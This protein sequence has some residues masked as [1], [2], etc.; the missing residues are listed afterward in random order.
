[1]GQISIHHFHGHDPTNW[2][3]EDGGYKTHIISSV[4]EWIAA[5]ALDFFILSFTQEF[6]TFTIQ[7]PRINLHTV[8]QYDILNSSQNGRNSM[9][10]SGTLVADL[11]LHSGI[12]H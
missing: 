8:E 7:T 10:Q 11:S 9:E 12:M 6:Q 2:K 1:M 4:A 5:M 3:P